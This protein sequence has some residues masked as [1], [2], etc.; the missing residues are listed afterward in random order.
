M[1]L[2]LEEIELPGVSYTKRYNGLIFY[3][4]NSATEKHKET[5]CALL[6]KGF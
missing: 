2:L 1:S 6:N 3:F 5:I 4:E